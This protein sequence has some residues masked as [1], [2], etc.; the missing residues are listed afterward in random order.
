VV[1]KQS[2]KRRSFFYLVDS[3]MLGLLQVTR[4]FTRL[5]P[6]S[7]FYSMVKVLGA[8]LYYGRPR[9]RRDLERKISDAM[10]EVT[11]R[12]KLDRIGRGTYESML[13]NVPD[14][15]YFERNAERFMEGLEVEGM[16][17]LQRAEARGKGVLIHMT[18]MGRSPILHAMMHHLGIPF[19]LVMWHPDTTPVPRYTMNMVIEGL[20]VGVDTDYLLI[21][22][23]PGHDTI[24]KVRTRLSRSERVGVPFDVPGK[25][26]VEFFGRPAAF[27]D[28]MAQFA[29]DSGAPIVPVI[30]ARTRR[31]YRNRLI[32]HEPLEYELTGDRR[33]DT[34]TIQQ[35]AARACERM[36]RLAP[37]QWMSWFGLWHWWSMAEELEA[38]SQEKARSG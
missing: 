19:T 31:P 32:I 22:V 13:L 4:L 15:L 29:F 3:A 27:A 35:E 11:S 24:G 16:E 8:A 5:L 33:T 10:P 37:E 1:E 12:R 25:R 28:G 38:A 36:I 20:K 2:L 14:F 7:I 21:W 6:P 9:V 23:G 17:N 34:Q 18:H 26:P 30:I